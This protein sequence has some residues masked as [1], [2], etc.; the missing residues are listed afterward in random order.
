MSSINAKAEL[1]NGLIETVTVGL[2]RDKMTEAEAVLAAIRVLR[3]GLAV[4]DTFDAWLALKRGR[5]SDAAIL[6]R[7]LDFD[8]A[9]PAIG[10]AL[11]ACCLFAVG[12][13]DWRVSANEV[14]AEDA[15]PDAVALVRLL[16]G[17]PALQNYDSVTTT[18]ATHSEDGSNTQTSHEV[19]HS[20][21][22]FLRV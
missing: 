3:P 15:D 8:Q 13:A 7:N 22:T 19:T 2:Q 12:D 1:V 17:Q 21:S 20:S 6:L 14:L 9:V 5:F 10:K 4:L 11:R 16:I 18:D